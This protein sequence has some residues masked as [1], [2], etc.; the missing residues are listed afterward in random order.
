MQIINHHEELD[1]VR[2]S[3]RDPNSNV[4]KFNNDFY[5]QIHASG[6]ADYK[7]LMH[8]GLYEKLQILGYLVSHD[9]VSTQND[10]T[11][12][13]LKPEQISFISYGYEWCF[14]QLKDAALLTL[15]VTKT[16]IEYG[17]ILKDASAYN[18]QFHHGKPI[19]ID[20]GSFARYLEGTPWLAYNQFCK[21][22]L[23]P[24]FLM[25]KKDIRLGLLSKEYIDGIPLDLAS[26][27]LPQKSKLS[28]SSYIHIHIHAKMQQK[29]SNSKINYKKTCRKVSKFG[30]LGL[31]DNLTSVINK[32]TFPTIKTEWSN[33]YHQTTYTDK[34]TQYKAEA[35]H[36]LIKGV[37]PLMIWDLG[38]N[39]GFY[40]NIAAEH[41]GTV[42][43]FD[44]DPVAVESNYREIKSKNRK[45]ILPLIQNLTNPS[46]TIGWAQSERDGLNERRNADMVMAL[47]LIHHLAITNNIPFN[48]IAHYFSS[49]GEHLIIEF[50]PKE[51]AQV[52][53]LLTNRDDIFDGYTIANFK[54]IFS[55]YF[56]ILQEIPLPETCRTIFL[57]RKRYKT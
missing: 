22:F 27:L 55:N 38:G 49:L 19:L 3:F 44:V 16:A 5:R 10:S 39:N 46:S 9:E 56:A 2:S 40:S 42:I 37:N 45:N 28:L 51:D 11:S 17:M 12:I 13:I 1:I 29:Y 24:L 48:K 26:S 7:Y 57:M 31:L 18:I 50:V 53:R 20:T 41:G 15:E 25:A 36:L 30:L 32:L 33:Y 21:H 54:N 14:S 52:Q 43:C 35:I 47:A 4:F 34:A 6:H 23:A 8:S